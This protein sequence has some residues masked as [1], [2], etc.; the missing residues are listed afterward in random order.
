MGPGVDPHLYKASEGDVLRLGR[1][2]VIFYSGLHL[3]AKM[4]EVIEKMSDRT[5]VVAVTDGIDRESLLRPAAFEGQYDPHVWFDVGMWMQ[6]TEAVRDAL[7]T[8]DPGSADLYRANADR[9]LGELDALQTTSGSG[10]QLPPGRVVI[11]PMPSTTSGA[12]GFRLSGLRACT[13]P[14]QAPCPQTCDFIAVRKIRNLHRIIRASAQC[15]AVQA[16]VRSRVGGRHPRGC[17]RTPWGRQGL[18][19]TYQG[20]VRHNIDTI[21]GT[22]LGKRGRTSNA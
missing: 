21:V 11:I 7:I 12:Y 20:M 22:L 1:A 18:D 19:G 4:A 16:A 9:Y 15:Q 14:G 6:A 8:L 10:P 17:T 5:R 3:E 13:A 2:D